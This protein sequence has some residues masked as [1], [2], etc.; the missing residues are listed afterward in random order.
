MFIREARTPYNK[1]FTL[2][3]IQPSVRKGQ[4]EGVET[5]GH[6]DSPKIGAI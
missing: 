2:R 6:I 1:V 4:F 3:A 5:V